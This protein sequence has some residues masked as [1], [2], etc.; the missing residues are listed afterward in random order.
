MKEN[1]STDSNNDRNEEN[2]TAIKPRLLKEITELPILP[3]EL[4]VFPYET[5][6]LK[7]ET[8]YWQQMIEK[9]HACGSVI[10]ITSLT[11]SEGEMPPPGSVGVASRILEIEKTSAG[12]LW[13]VKVEGILRYEI[14]SYPTTD[15][16][17]PIARI[18]YFEDETD[19][20]DF[21]MELISELGNL[22][23]RLQ[24]YALERKPGEPL[25]MSK[26]NPATIGVLSFGLFKLISLNAEQRDML[27][28]TRRP[29][30]R[31]YILN[32]ELRNFLKRL[33][34]MPQN[35]YFN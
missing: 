4:V 33:D 25:D 2:E 29:G 1:E 15:H 17:Y 30:A 11:Q 24:V 14:E 27:L 34:A 28:K 8:D 22:L 21:D 13:L 6:V 18:N 31:L 32:S 12:N 9:I 26:V 10:G 5:M 16:H 19:L 35:F 20:N 3:Q 7:L 23:D